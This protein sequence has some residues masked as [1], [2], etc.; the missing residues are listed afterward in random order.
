MDAP[1]WRSLVFAALDR[2]YPLTVKWGDKGRMQTEI[3]NHMHSIGADLSNALID[4]RLEVIRTWHENPKSHPQLSQVMARLPNDMGGDRDKLCTLHLQS[5]SLQK[6]TDSERRM[7]IKKIELLQAQG[8]CIRNAAVSNL[9]KSHD[10]VEATPKNIAELDARGNRDDSQPARDDLPPARDDSLPVRDDALPVRDDPLPAPDDQPP[11]PD[12]QPPA[13]VDLPP[14]RSG[15]SS[16]LPAREGSSHQSSAHDASLDV[17]PARD[18]H[19]V[20]PP[21]R[22]TPS[23]EVIDL[24]KSNDEGS[25]SGRPDEPPT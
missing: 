19:H 24:A 4:K 13:G 2:K 23:D 12:D 20:V 21:P 6:L 3:R 11:A 8:D 1:M 9:K 14:A 22:P 5:L 15:C 18:D 7:K 16:P 17:S 25:V 10:L